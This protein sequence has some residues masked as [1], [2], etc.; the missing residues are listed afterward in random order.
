M[1]F[2][3]YCLAVALMV[4]VASTAMA[5]PQRPASFDL[6][7]RSLDHVDV[8]RLPAVDNEALLDR[9]EGRFDSTNPEALQ[10][11]EPFDVALSPASRGTWETVGD[12]RIWRLVVSSGGAFS[13]NAGFS[14]FN[15]PAGAALWLYPA[16]GTPA[17]RALTARDHQPDGQLWTPIVPGDEIVIELNLPAGDAGYA[18][19]LARLSHAY[20]PFGI[21]GADLSVGRSGSC[22]VDVVCPEGDDYRDIIRSSATYSRGGSRVCSGAAINNTAQ[23]GAPLF[24]TAN[25]CGMTA[26]NA[27]SMVVYWNYEN[28]SCR[29]VGQSGGHGDGQLTQFNT[30][31]T[32]RGSGSG[33]DWALVELNTEIDPEYHVYLSGWDRRNQATASAVAIHHPR[34]QEKRISF[35]NN[36]TQITTY[37][38]STPSSS[39]THIHV[40]DWDLGTTEPGSS[41]SPL[42]SPEQ[43]IVGQL[44]GGYAACSNNL[45]DWY[46]RIH[47]SMN[48]GM[49][50]WLDPLNTGAEY[51][52][53]REAGDA[54]PELPELPGGVGQAM[55]FDGGNAIVAGPFNNLP[56]GE[57]I[58]LSLWAK[59]SGPG[60]L[61][62]LSFDGAPGFRV[63]VVEDG[64]ALFLA[65]AHHTGAGAHVTRVFDQLALTEDP[66]HI[67]VT[68]GGE[69][70]AVRLFVDGHR[71]G[72]PFFY[73]A[74]PTASGERVFTVGNDASGE[75]GVVSLLDEVRLYRERLTQNALQAA[76]HRTYH[77]DDAPSALVTYYRFDSDTT[78]YV[79]DFSN[80]G[81]GG[82]VVMD[83]R[84]MS[85]FPVGEEAVLLASAATPSGT[86][87]PDGL[88]VH[89]HS[90][91]TL[92]GARQ[93]G[94]Y[95][96]STTDAVL[97]DDDLP[98]DLLGRSEMIW[99]AY[100][101][102]EIDAD[103]SIDFS[104]LE[105]LEGAAPNRML[106]RERP[107][108]EWVDASHLWSFSDSAALLQGTTE[109]GEWAV[110]YA[111]PV[112]GE[113]GAA[114]L[115]ARLSN[116]YPNP[117][118]ESTTLNLDVPTA[119]EVTVE[120]VDLLGRRVLLLHEGH[121]TA[122]SQTLELDGAR[123]A[124]GVY[125]VRASGVDFQLVQRVTLV[126]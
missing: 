38:S 5:Q 41:G 9:D 86:L 95:I 126:R 23:D 31:A 28:S 98:E 67:A 53:G 11:A 1:S 90:N 33:S 68:R 120:V 64:G 29:P 125:L 121:A 32:L 110:G 6:E 22:N 84:V 44:H 47:T 93:L 71:V 63:D 88:S 46:G 45:A 112:S 111:L 76:M 20:R 50:Q 70:A 94:I 81:I 15:L 34:T 48:A 16:G 108:A 104:G 40:I 105:S 37:L 36:P 19:E 54:L 89:A 101:H 58:S 3:R 69:P 61:A 56:Q 82:E 123:L 102:G 92:G 66:H 116:A 85:P 18:L 13:L 113:D 117:F 72:T 27:S 8:Y 109:F 43:R 115:A 39:G 12:T 26:G 14:H 24:L 52:D 118:R 65:Y 17:F 80:H 60:T 97:T 91:T 51:I 107:D 57:E 25:H 119:G 79:Y 83:E 30:G 7:V 114:P 73:S 35:E 55:V 62:E 75:N 42:Y 2:F 59:I 87:G 99:A 10:F 103:V 96:R 106:F 74:G 77:P 78:G 124:P 122:G 4:T 49:A 21:P 100:A